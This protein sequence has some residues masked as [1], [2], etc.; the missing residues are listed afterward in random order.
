M[1]SK[2]AGDRVSTIYASSPNRLLAKGESSKLLVFAAQQHQS[3]SLNSESLERLFQNL[4]ADAY[5]VREA[6]TL[7]L[8]R[9]GK[10]VI[11]ALE[12]R[13][14]T[15]LESRMRKA[16]IARLV[17]DDSFPDLNR[18]LTCTTPLSQVPRS[19]AIDPE[20]QLFVISVNDGWK[21]KLLI[22]SIEEKSWCVV[23]QIA[24]R[25]RASHITSIADKPGHFA[26]AFVDG[27]IDVI[28]VI[29][30]RSADK[31]TAI[32]PR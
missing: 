8:V 15:T 4:D 2:S 31:P 30:P 1:I 3:A 24:L 13:Q 14:T 9:G 11:K 29:P 23:T 22:C 16:K 20:G 12:N 19:I 27:T 10:E 28:Q 32:A 17:K 7:A 6:A 26:V 25:S 5:E 21:S 18:P